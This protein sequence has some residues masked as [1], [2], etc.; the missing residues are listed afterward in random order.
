[1]R[2]IVQRVS[3]AAVVVDGATVGEI[4]RG[5]CVLL[6]ICQSDTAQDADWMSKK[7]LNLRLFDEND[8]QGGKRWMKSV[9]DLG[10]EVLVVSQ[11]TLHATLKAEKMYADILESMRRDYQEDKIK[12]GVFG[13]MMEVSSTNCGPSIHA[14]LLADLAD[15]AM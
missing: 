10:L 2:A 9:R 4:G 7:L 11:F 6:G 1:M 12:A 15:L 8:E 3:R 5:I 13:A 14:Q